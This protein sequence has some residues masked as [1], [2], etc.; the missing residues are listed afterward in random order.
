MKDH[1]SVSTFARR[2]GLSVR[3]VRLWCSRG[4]IPG[5]WQPGDYNGAWQI[6]LSTY[7]NWPADPTEHAE[8]AVTHA[9]A[10]Q[11]AP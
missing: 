8:R 11:P 5:A 1:V 4:R 3:T 7:D 2:Y 10:E 9:N 6:P